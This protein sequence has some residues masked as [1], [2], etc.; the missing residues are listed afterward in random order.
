MVVINKDR[1]PSTMDFNIL[2]FLALDTDA[3]WSYHGS[4]VNHIC[5]F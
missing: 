1:F 2:P 3:W 5:R 4:Q